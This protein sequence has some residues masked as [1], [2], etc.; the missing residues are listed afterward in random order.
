MDISAEQ[1]LDAI[2]I[3]DGQACS[4]LACLEFECG[5]RVAPVA[6]NWMR[7]PRAAWRRFLMHDAFLRYWKQ[8]TG[9]ALTDIGRD[10]HGYHALP[11]SLSSLKGAAASGN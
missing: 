10:R 8:L 9:A 1:K 7:A 11:R 6:R 3:E 4:P 5:T 2:L